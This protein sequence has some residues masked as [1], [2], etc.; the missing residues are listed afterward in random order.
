[1]T[2]LTSAV[3]TTAGDIL[4][5]GEDGAIYTRLPPTGVQYQ[6]L[7]PGQRPT[8]EWQRI[9]PPAGVTP[10]ALLPDP[11]HG[12]GYLLGTDGHLYERRQNRNDML[13]QSFV[14]HEIEGP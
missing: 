8:H 5:I 2:R 13:R 12:L 10:K 14:W 6:G 3:S 1:M 9:E 4:A 11:H 7:P